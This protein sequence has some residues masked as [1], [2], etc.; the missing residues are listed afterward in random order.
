VHLIRSDCEGSKALDGTDDAMLWNDNEKD[1]D[2]RSEYQEDEGTDCDN[3]G[4]DT[5]W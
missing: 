4:S 3:G 5:N 1:G 2:V